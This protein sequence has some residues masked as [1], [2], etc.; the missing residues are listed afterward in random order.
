MTA[1]DPVVARALTYPYETPPGS[2]VLYTA[3]ER[4]TPL[5]GADV[6]ELA[7]GRR[8]LLAVG[9]NAAPSQLFHKFADFAGDPMIPVIAVD[10]A[11]TDVV[12]AAR[13]SP[14]GA[15]PA[16]IAGSPGTTAYVKVTLLSPGQFDR[17]NETESLG[18]GY[19]LVE[20]P[21]DRI[22]VRGQGLDVVLPSAGPVACYR[23]IAGPMKLT[24]APV[25]L[26]A[27]RATARRWPARTEAQMLDRLATVLGLDRE[28]LINQVVVNSAY[29]MAL[30][31]R[32]RSG[33]L[34]LDDR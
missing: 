33:E 17:M 14:Y 7:S 26:Q 16:T 24:G 19:E 12:F 31:E 11:D 15:I 18:D 6:S 3:S 27:V 28:A 8:L 25:A 20:F 22:R 2:Y 34:T 9:S 10:A 29:Q 1:T 21:A 23:A 13:V 30:N 5:R 4:I 32:L